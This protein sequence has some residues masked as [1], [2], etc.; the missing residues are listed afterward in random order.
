MTNLNDHIKEI[1]KEF[2]A[3]F[4]VHIQCP[5]PDCAK[6]KYLE[7]VIHGDKL[8]DFLTSKLREIATAT[9]GACEVEETFSEYDEGRFA[10][11]FHAA[12][13]EQKKKAEE[14]LNPKT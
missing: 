9:L 6:V 11:G 10:L 4:A 3:R 13:S 12:I 1:E 8:S 2:E 5:Y 14:W 7:C